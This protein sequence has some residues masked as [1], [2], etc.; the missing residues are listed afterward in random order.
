MGRE[1]L[2]KKV[3]TKDFLS[4][5]KSEDDVSRFLKDLH[6][7]VL[8]QLL[9]D[10]LDSHLGYEKYSVAGNNSGNSRNGSFPKTIQTQHGESTIQIPRDRNGEFE[11]IVVPKHESRALHRA[12]GYLTL[13]QRNECFR[14]R[15]RASSYL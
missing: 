12:I 1:V 3:L 8:E 13:R 14:H 5:C 4:Q 10:E 9:Q 7:Q 11:P 6:S 15:R 2:P